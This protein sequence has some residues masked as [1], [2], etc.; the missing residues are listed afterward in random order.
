MLIIDGDE[1][2]TVHAKV[3]RAIES[4]RRIEGAA[5]EPMVNLLA[6]VR[7]GRFRVL[8]FPRRAH[9]PA[10][11]SAKGPDRLAISPAILEMCGVLVSTEA[12]DFARIDADTARQIYD[13]VSVAQAA[14]EQLLADL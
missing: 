14:F 6:H 11:Y 13:E 5:D 4:L 10:C 12:A 2:T 7:D 9:R 1:V 8:L 3:E